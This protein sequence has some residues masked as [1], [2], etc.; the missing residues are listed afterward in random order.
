MVQKQK[1]T[2]YALIAHAFETAEEE[3]EGGE[4]KHSNIEGKGDLTM[5]KKRI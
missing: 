4:T 3:K 1:T 5:K 2:M